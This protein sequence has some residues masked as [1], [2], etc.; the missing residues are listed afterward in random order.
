VRAAASCAFCGIRKEALSPYTV[1]GEHT[2]APG[3]DIL[4]PELV[5]RIHL[6]VSDAPRMTKAA[7]DSLGE[8]GLT[9]AHYVEALGIAAVLRSIV[10]EMGPSQIEAD[11]GP[12]EDPLQAADAVIGFRRIVRG[13]ARNFGWNASFMARPVANRPGSG[14][15]VHLSVLDERGENIFS[16]GGQAGSLGHVVGGCLARLA[17]SQ[18]IFAP[19]ANSY[20]RYEPRGHAPTAPTWGDDNRIAALRIPRSSDRSRRM[21]HRVAG[22]DANP[23]L[24]IAAILAAALDGIDRSVDPGPAA[25][26][27]S[28]PEESFSTFAWDWRAAIER[29]EKSEWIEKAFG[30]EFQRVFVACKWQ[31]H[32]R[33]LG[34]IPDV[35]LDAYLD[36]V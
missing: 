4:A 17:D 15:H 16:Q 19:H 9:A 5:D 3:S 12:L 7:I 20:R 28:V 18:L 25:V 32:D 21:E 2:S 36:V 24:V 26:G 35:E 29:F 30:S 27:A 13:F 1:K 10:C 33:L 23:Y 6:A 14:M 31:E 11:L 8:V 22:A 34:P